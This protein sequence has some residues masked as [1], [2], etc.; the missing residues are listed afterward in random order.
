MTESSGPFEGNLERLF[1][2]A[3]ALDPRDRDAF[4]EI[5][6]RNNTA[7]EIELSSLLEADDG[8]AETFMRTPLPEALEVA[9]RPEVPERYALEEIVAQGGMG[10]VLK[11]WDKQLERAVAMK[12]MAGSKGSTGE[13]ANRFIQEARI[14]GQLDHPGIVPVYDLG[15][16]GDCRSYFTMPLVRGKTL[17]RAFEDLELVVGFGRR[18]PSH[19]LGR[20]FVDVLGFGLGLALVDLELVG[21]V[22]GHHLGWRRLGALTAGEHRFEGIL[23]QYHVQVLQVK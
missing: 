12:V 14:T 2:A 20:N 5:A 11:V 22:R 10:F 17:A 23:I 15:I 19:G 7:L 16:G 4:L 6:C 18:F 13:S 3:L 21:F 8:L 1:E 9:P